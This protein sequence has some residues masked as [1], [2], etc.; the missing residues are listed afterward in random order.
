MYQNVRNRLLFYKNVQNC[1]YASISYNGIN[2]GL[3]F[4]CVSHLNMAIFLADWS[5]SNGN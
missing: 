1:L 5:D 4:F 2:V 3:V